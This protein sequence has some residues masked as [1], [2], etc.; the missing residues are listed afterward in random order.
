MP[1]VT[2]VWRVEL[3]NEKQRDVEGRGGQRELAREREGETERR[4]CT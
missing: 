1:N 2:Y 3:G 4:E